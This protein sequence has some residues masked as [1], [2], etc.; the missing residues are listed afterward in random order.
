MARR[1]DEDGKARIGE[2]TPEGPQDRLYRDIARRLMERINNGTYPLG[3]R[4]PAERE[5][6]AEFNVS[7]PTVRE[8]IIALEVQ[9][10]VEVRVGSGA[11]VRRQ[12]SAAETPGFGVTAFELTEARLLFEGEAAALAAT[13]IS[14]EELAELAALVE[15][16]AGQ[17]ATKAEAADREFHMLIARAT[18]NAAIVRTI[19]SLWNLRQTSPDCALLHAKARTAQ[20]KPVVE[21][22]M[23]VVDAL[24]SR[25]PA[26]ARNA[27]RTHLGAVIEHLLFATEEEAIER[28]KQAAQD[29]RARFARSISM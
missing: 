20:V 16:I 9:G 28:A 5:I 11:Y 12:T 4:L 2:G 6:S 7:R 22:H 10:V 24:R 21:E 25:E 23:A 8:A 13:N 1:Q 17:D 27:M 15:G 29:T 19:D 26:R 18:R 14:D 3:G